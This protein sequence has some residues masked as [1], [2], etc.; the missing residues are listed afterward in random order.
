MRKHLWSTVAVLVMV[1]LAFGSVGKQ[2]KSDVPV[3]EQKKSDVPVGEQKESDVPVGEQK[4]SDVR[5]EDTS[6][7]TPDQVVTLG[8]LQ[9][10]IPSA[11]I[12]NVGLRNKLT[13]RIYYYKGNSLCIEIKI[14][15]TNKTKRIR[16]STW[17]D[18]A[19][20][21]DNFGNKYTRRNLEGYTFL[22]G[23]PTVESAININPETSVS[24]TLLFEE[25]IDRADHLL[26]EMPASNCGYR[27]MVRF[28][29]PMQ[30][31]TKR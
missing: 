1:I 26:L 14:S 8:D 20:L 12:R 7:A 11:W 25:P 27:G 23:Y 28:K 31:I 5:K 10:S 2:K 19:T 3:G 29:I 22:G 15:N 4:E 30:F 9:I 13:G 6:W 17:R 18:D 24:D 16:Y 21:K